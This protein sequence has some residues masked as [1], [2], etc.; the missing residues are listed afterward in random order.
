MPFKTINGRKVF[1]NDLHVKN[2][3]DIKDDLINKGISLGELEDFD[4]TKESQ[5]LFADA[6]KENNFITKTEK[7][8][9]LNHP[10]L[11][12]ASELKNKEVVK[13][14]VFG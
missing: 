6:F 3:Q 13:T 1:M 8:W 2:S 12:K 4:K 9:A 7:F 5:K 14:G 11:I 10:E